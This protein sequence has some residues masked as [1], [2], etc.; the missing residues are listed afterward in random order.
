[1]E[2]IYRSRHVVTVPKLNLDT[3]CWIPRAEIFWDEQGT[4]SR[5]VLT[6]LSDYYKIIDEAEIH[7]LEIARAWIDAE[8]A[9]DLTP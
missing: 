4:R 3:D 8:L 2:V 1:M 5:Q 7:A 9:D 6:G